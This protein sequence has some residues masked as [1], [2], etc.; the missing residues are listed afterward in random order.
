MEKLKIDKTRYFPTIKPK[1]LSERALLLKEFL[2]IIN[3]QTNPPYKP[4]TPARLG[5]LLAPI[6]TKDLY[7]FL[8][9]C[10]EA[11]SFAKFFWWS[12]KK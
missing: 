9:R 1:N 11:K 7:V 8:S 6:K 3:S 2:E 5:M 10:K 12:F 4:L